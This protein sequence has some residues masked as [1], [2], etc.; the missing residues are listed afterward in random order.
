M[1]VDF[2]NPLDQEFLD[3]LYKVGRETWGDDIT[4]PRQFIIGRLNTDGSVST[5]VTSGE[6]GRVWVRE[7]G[8]DTGDAVQ[9]INTVLQA[10]EIS[11]DRPVMVKIERGN[12]VIINKAAESADYDAQLPVAPQRAINRGQYNVALITPSAPDT[13]FYAYYRGGMFQLNNTVYRITDIPSSDFSGTVPVANALSIK[14][15]LDPVTG[16]WYETTG[17]AF[18]TTSLINAFKDG[19]LNT[20]RTL[21]R[22]FIGWIRLYDGQT[23]IE[24]DDILL[25]E[26]MLGIIDELVMGHMY[27]PGID[28]IVE[29]TD[30]NP[31]EVFDDGTT[32]VG[33]GWAAGELNDV[34]FP[35]GG[36]EHYLTVTKPG[37]YEIIWNMSFM[38]DGPGAN[39]QVHAGIMIDG[40]ATRNRGEAH[41]TIANNSDTGLIAANAIIDCPNGTE[42]ISLWV[43]NSDN[44]VDITIAHG[45]VTIKLIG[46]T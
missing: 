3:E 12:F 38:M 31:T 45:D 43:L 29:I 14:V 21:G 36:D 23:A 27:I 33:D 9:A 18:T 7:P 37:K 19:D 35:T 24:L 6:Y 11:P 25:A 34:T 42:Q 13:S 2:D 17:S 40:T 41:E 30:G 8:P 26:Y 15:E 22:F 4:R 28:I 10:D 46:S 39:I 32:S 5:V 20:T 16:T 1:M 44:N